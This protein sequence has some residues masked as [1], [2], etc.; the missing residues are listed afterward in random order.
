MLAAVLSL[1]WAGEPSSRKAPAKKSTGK[2]PSKVSKKPAPPKAGAKAKP[3]PPKAG[4]KASSKKAG[5]SP[6]KG[7]AGT[8][9]YSRRPAVQQQPTPDRY[10]QIEQALAQ[11]GY[12]K[13]EPNGAWNVDAQDALKRFQQDQ[14]LNP[15]GKID[16]LSLIALGLGPKRTAAPERSSAM[17]KGQP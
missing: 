17:P 13:G 3:S 12:L 7:K 10:R 6:S 1:G 11:R 16:S 4:A 14:N 5:T 15:T 9:R 8:R 2:A